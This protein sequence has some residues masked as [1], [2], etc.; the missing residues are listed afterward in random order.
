[1]IDLIALIDWT[2]WTSVTYCSLG[3]HVNMISVDNSVN[4]VKPPDGPASLGGFLQTEFGFI[5]CVCR[6]ER[7]QPHDNR[8]MD[9]QDRREADDKVSI[10]RIPPHPTWDARIIQ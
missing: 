10:Q 9:G 1:M 3:C 4:L 8:R 7:G 2:D 6:P 5:R